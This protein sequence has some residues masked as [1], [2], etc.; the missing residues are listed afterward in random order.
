MI[1]SLRGVCGGVI[2]ILGSL[3]SRQ[4]IQHFSQNT[5]FKNR[6]LRLH[7]KIF[8]GVFLLV[9]IDVSVSCL[10]EGFSGFSLLILNCFSLER[11]Q[12]DKSCAVR[13]RQPTHALDGGSAV[14]GVLGGSCALHSKAAKTLFIQVRLIKLSNSLFPYRIGL[15]AQ[16]NGATLKRTWKIAPQI[17][18]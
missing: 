9:F 3:G 5:T 18:G 6:G 12:F 1:V 17:A 15:G 7:F 4:R 16:K 10:R 11:V 2:S 8:T 13:I 14:M